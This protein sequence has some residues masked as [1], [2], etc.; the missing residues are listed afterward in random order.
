M[1]FEWLAQQKHVQEVTVVEAERIIRCAGGETEY[2]EHPMWVL[3]VTLG[4]DE[5]AFEVR[6][7][8][9]GGPP[10]INLTELARF[11]WLARS[12]GRFAQ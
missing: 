9:Y 10:M 3:H 1:N 2:C 11:G 8:P 6:R 12:T 7:N 5:E 4:D